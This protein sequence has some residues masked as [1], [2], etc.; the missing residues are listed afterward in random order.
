MIPSAATSCQQCSDVDV[1]GEVGQ[2][3]IGERFDR[4]IDQASSK[5]RARA[6]GVDIAM[7]CR[8]ITTMGSS[9]ATNDMF[10]I[11]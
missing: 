2:V 11:G 8:P 6:G 1:F 7:Y 3:E 5:G 10:D 9:L 4:L